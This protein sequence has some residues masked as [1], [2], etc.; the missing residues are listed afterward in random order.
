MPQTLN[1][2]VR[3]IPQEVIKSLFFNKCASSETRGNSSE[4]G[5]VLKLH[6]VMYRKALSHV[7]GGL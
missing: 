6:S 5:L 7:L 4:T 2:H 1:M 3:W